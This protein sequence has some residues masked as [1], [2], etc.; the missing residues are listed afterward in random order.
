M[1]RVN[2]S[3]INVENVSFS[4]GQKTDIL[5]DVSLRVAQGDYLG[6]I[7]PN[8]GG[9]TTLLKIMLGLLKPRTGVVSLFGVPLGRFKQWSRIGYVSQRAIAF[10]A[11]FPVTV[12]EVVRMGRY[13]KRGFFRR[14]TAEDMQK[15]EEALKDVEMAEFRKRRVSDLSGGQKQRVFL[16]RA[17][18]SE[19]DCV[20]LD[21]PTSGVDHETEERFFE[22]L[23]M[24]NQE[25]GMTLVLVSHDLE[26]I[27]R[28]A[29]AVAVVDKSL[30]YYADPNEALVHEEG[31]ADAHAV[32]H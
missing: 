6:L 17:L 8:G 26:R 22:L 7:G 29:S 31:T 2:E 30:R 27:A 24:L 21:E 15:A 13:A 12:E 20:V 28:E 1:Y 14:L 4:Y 16:A 23:R 19:P 3:T 18:A 9:K 25:R 5:S 32:H 10:D 11:L